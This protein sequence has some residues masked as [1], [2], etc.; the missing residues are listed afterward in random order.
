MKR[1]MVMTITEHVPAYARNFP[2]IA[3]TLEQAR[4]PFYCMNCQQKGP[5]GWPTPN[6]G[7]LCHECAKEGGYDVS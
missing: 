6:F 1:T 4:L 3:E 2:R 5:T 7:P